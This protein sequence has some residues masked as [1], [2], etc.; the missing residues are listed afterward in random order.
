VV[1]VVSPPPP[2]PPAD[3]PPTAAA[4]VLLAIELDG[5]GRRAARYQ[6]ERWLIAQPRSL[7]LIATFLE[8]ID[9]QSNVELS[10]ESQARVTFRSAWSRSA[11]TAALA[12]TLSSAASFDHVSASASAPVVC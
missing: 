11:A 6:R 3:A 2:P 1:V 10:V 8:A 12:D 5:S 4:A 7:A 9:R